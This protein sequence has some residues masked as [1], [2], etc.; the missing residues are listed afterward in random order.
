MLGLLFPIAY[1]AMNCVLPYILK[2]DQ[3]QSLADQEFFD[4]FRPFP[5]LGRPGVFRLVSRETD[6]AYLHVP[7]RR[8]AQSS[9]TEPTSYEVG[10]FLPLGG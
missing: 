5:E 1:F 8:W 7:P 10:S 3:F 4:S 2:T 9:L 6:G